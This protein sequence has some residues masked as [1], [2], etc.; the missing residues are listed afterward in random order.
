MRHAGLMSLQTK[1]ASV[2]VYKSKP[3]CVVWGR[4]LSVCV[5]G[6]IRYTKNQQ[7]ADTGG[8]AAEKEAR[9]SL[10]PNEKKPKKSLNLHYTGRFTALR[11]PTNLL[12]N[13]AA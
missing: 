11:D 6:V 10:K 13:P 7:N 3:P 8:K 4:A 1:R 9:Y 12:H 2:T 5:G